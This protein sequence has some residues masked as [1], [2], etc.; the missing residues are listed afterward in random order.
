MTQASTPKIPQGYAPPLNLLE[1][2]LVL[3]TGA[4]G[5]LGRTLA[6]AAARHGATVILHGRDQDKLEAVY[7]EIEASGGPEPALFVLDLH[8]EEETTYLGFA[9]RIERE[10]GRLDALVHCAALLPYF[11]RIDDY[12]QDM[13]RKALQVNLTA[14]FLLTQAMLPLLRRQEHASIIFTLDGAHQP[15]KA[16]R[17]AYGVA[18]AGLQQLM[19]VLAN[20]TSDEGR[21]RCNGID[22]GPMRS[23]L[24]I[25][26]YPGISPQSLPDPAERA[27]AYLY[28]LGDDSL[29]VNGHSFCL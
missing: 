20:E 16:Y 26:A 29:G 15:G 8:I 10:F 28:L 23:N 12:D 24:R 18:K 4:T 5:G 19:E 1:Q 14:P 27:P 11:S 17:G 22:P 6:L 9:R 7:D 25:R 13:W 3:I 2:R 21:I